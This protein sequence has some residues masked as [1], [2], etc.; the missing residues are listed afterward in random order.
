ML[1]IGDIG[2]TNTRLALFEYKNGLK[3]VKEH[4]FLS[5]NFT[6]L[7]FAIKEFL[8][9]DKVNIEAASFGIA[10][11]IREGRCQATNI[12]WI[13]ETKVI[14]ETF[15]IKNVFLINDLEANAYGIESLKEDE[16][17]TLNEGK[18]QKGNACLLAAGTGLGEAGF[19]FDGKNYK[20]FACE[21]G[22]TDFAPRDEL[23]IELFK[24]LQ[25]KYG[26]VSY[27]RIVSG[28]GIQKIYEFLVDTKKEPKIESFE[29][30]LKKHSEPQILITQKGINKEIKGCEKAIDIF[31]SVYGAETGNMALKLFALGGVYVGGGIAPK[32]INKL[33]EGAFIKAFADKGRFSSLMMSIPV[34]V[35]LNDKAALLGAARYAT[36]Y[37][38]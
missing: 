3:C 22:H 5:S 19:Y 29:K 6:S 11:P 17:L 21:G 25:K 4:R 20:P 7:V 30:E 18:K 8:K 9:D 31:I 36:I 34:K 16:F 24:F 35:I 37:K 13:V 33:Q 2:G 1:L 12:P 32:M 26:H 27:E 15:K 10:G 38:K 23:E 28:P 14:T